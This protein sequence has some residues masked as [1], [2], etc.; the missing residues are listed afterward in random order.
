MFIKSNL[1][2]TK[3]KKRISNQGNNSNFSCLNLKSNKS[4]SMIN[5]N[6]CEALGYR[7][8]TYVYFSK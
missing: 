4:I 3:L 1:K 8:A 2:N 5:S 6:G 7:N